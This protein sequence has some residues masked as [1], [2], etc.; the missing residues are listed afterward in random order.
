M[1]WEIDR[2]HSL[3]EFSVQH[4]MI[5]TVKGKFTEVYG[6]IETD[7]QYP[8]RSSVRAQIIANSIHTNAPQRDVHLRTADF[9]EATKYPTITFNSTAIKHI[10]TN[11]FIVG[12]D[13]SMHGVTR[14][15]QLRTLYTGINQDHLTN[16]WRI[17]LRA[18]TIIDRR[19]FGMTYGETNK[20]GI[21]LAGNEIHIDI[22]L[23]AIWTG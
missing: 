23:E 15:V 5:S 7:P 16:A 17:G 21:A 9:F 8:E 18:N 22:F 12:G 11:R 1:A 13:L 4:L 14:P 3:V 10:D 2:F 20:A 6:T 19:N